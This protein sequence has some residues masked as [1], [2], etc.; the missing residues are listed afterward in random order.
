MPPDEPLASAGENVMN[1][2]LSYILGGRSGMHITV[3][4]LITH[5]ITHSMMRRE[6]ISDESIHSGQTYPNGDVGWTVEGAAEWVADAGDKRMYP[7]TTASSILDRLRRDGLD[8][9]WDSD[10]YS[11]AFL[12]FKF[13]NEKFGAST[14]TAVSNSLEGGSSMEEAILANTPYTAS[15]LGDAGP[16]SGTFEAEFQDWATE[17]INA[18]EYK[19]INPTRG[20]AYT[21]NNPDP[22]W[23]DLFDIHIGAE[24][25]ETLQIRTPDVRAGALDYLGFVDV[26]THDLCERSLV[27]IDKALDM[28]NNARS[29]IGAKESRLLGVIRELGTM[30]ENES[31]AV[32]RIKDLDFGYEVTSFTRD[33]ILSQTGLAMLAQANQLP[34]MVLELI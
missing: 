11:E 33:Q 32:S 10:D 3:E 8:I 7:S 13:L 27:N 20:L 2:N 25:N 22:L 23:S 30:L 15:G 19:D 1:L 18:D 28:L 29:D 4:Q 17:Y 9:D 16:P 31:A 26:S 6:G 5:E 14:V 34:Q 24:V 12:V 21:P